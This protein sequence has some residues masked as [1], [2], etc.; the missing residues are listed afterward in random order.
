MPQEIIQEILKYCLDDISYPKLENGKKSENFKKVKGV[1]KKLNFLSKD[2]LESY[3]KKNKLLFDE[4]N[5]N[6][7]KFVLELINKGADINLKGD[8]GWTPLI[9]AITNWRNDLVDIFIKNGANVNLS[10]EDGFSPLI[11]ASL[12]GNTKIV[13]L[14]IE[15]GANINQQSNNGDTALSLAQINNHKQVIE[16][17]KLKGGK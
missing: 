4:L 1:C 6:D 3:D 5:K 17:L 16:L 9:R 7:F 11:W 8:A 13:K 2:F 14:L 12:A 10:D 15:N